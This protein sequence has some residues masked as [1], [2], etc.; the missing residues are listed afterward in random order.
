M[1][2][3][4]VPARASRLQFTASLEESRGTLPS[5]RDLKDLAYESTELPDAGVERGHGRRQ[6]VDVIVAVVGHREKSRGPHRT[7]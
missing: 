5:I 6:I 4:R 2:A 7:Y 1:M 3:A